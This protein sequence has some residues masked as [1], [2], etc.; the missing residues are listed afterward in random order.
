MRTSI[1]TAFLVVGVAAGYVTGLQALSRAGTAPAADGSKW[2]QQVVNY[3]DLYSIYSVGHF[4]SEGLLPPPRSSQLFSRL[5][6]EEGKT[7]RG[8]CS[9]RI[10]GAAL[11]ARWWALSASPVGQPALGVSATAGD[12][13]LTGDGRLEITLSRRVASGNWLAIPDATNIEVTLALQEVYDK[14]KKIP[15]TLPAL[16]KVSCE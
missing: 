2:E 13:L 5:T 14:D 15:L 1:G 11:P 8:S 9:Y 12:T 10:T 6:D 16:T 7:L 3:K 4:R